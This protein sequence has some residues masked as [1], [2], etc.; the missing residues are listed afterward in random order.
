MITHCKSSGNPKNI[1]IVH[2]LSDVETTKAIDSII[3]IEV[4]DLFEAKID[5]FILSTNKAPSKIKFFSS[6]QDGVGVR[7]FILAK[8]G[9]EAAAMW[10]R[11]SI[12]GIMMIL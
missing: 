6:T 5:S 8:H 12:D 11:Q 2:N 7:H 3:K 1:I 4:E 9:S 10:N